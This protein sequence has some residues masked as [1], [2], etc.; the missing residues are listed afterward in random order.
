MRLRNVKNK[1]IIMEEADSLIKDPFPYCGKWKEYFKNVEYDF[2]EYILEDVRTILNTY[3]ENYYVESDTQEEWFNRIK[4]MCDNLGYASNMK[5]YRENPE[6]YKGSVVDVT[7]IIRI[8]LTT[9]SNTPDLFLLMK[10]LGEDKVKERFLKC[11]N[12]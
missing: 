1:E 4:E 12:N 6:N 11:I 10:L 3:V 7:N 8:A 9:L 2:G 5:A